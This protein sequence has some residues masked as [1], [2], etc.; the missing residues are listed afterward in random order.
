MSTQV[1]GTCG[2]CGGPV[3]MPSMMVDPVARCRVC[4]ASPRDAYGPV[5]PMKSGDPFAEQTSQEPPKERA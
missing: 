3:E 2:N 1:I 5:I 4:G